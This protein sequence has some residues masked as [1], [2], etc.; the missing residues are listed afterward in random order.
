[1]LPSELDKLYHGLIAEI[2]EEIEKQQVKRDQTEE[3]SLDRLE[4]NSILIGLQQCKGVV[5]Y[6]FVKRLENLLKEKGGV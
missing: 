3:N 1:M 4:A 2:D 5:L 6:Y